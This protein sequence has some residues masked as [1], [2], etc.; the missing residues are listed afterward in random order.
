[1]DLESIMTVTGTLA[2][3]GGGAY[4]FRTF[5][6]KFGSALAADFGYAFGESIGQAIARGASQALTGQDLDPRVFETA[7]LRAKRW[8]YTKPVLTSYLGLSVSSIALCMGV[9]SGIPASLLEVMTH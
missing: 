1:M 2:L 5:L 3:I 9:C 4:G 6:P 7:E 8:S